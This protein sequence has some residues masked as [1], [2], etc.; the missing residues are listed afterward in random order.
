[1]RSLL[2]LAA[3]LTFTS[4]VRAQPETPRALFEE[5]VRAL[6]EQR[7]A[8]AAD[9]LA[10]S[11]ALRDSPSARYNRALALRGAGRYLEAIAEAE[12][13][14]EIAE[15]PR[16]RRVRP[17]VETLLEELRGAVATL[18]LVVTGGAETVLVDA[19]PVADVD[20]RHALRLDPGEHQVRV[21]RSGFA[22]LLRDIE[23]APGS[24]TT[25]DLDV[26]ATPLPASVRIEAEPATA[27]IVWDGR[28]V[29]EG[30]VDL[31]VPVERQG[32]R[33]R[34]EVR[35]DGFVSEEREL[36]LS[37]GESARLGLALSEEPAT[38]LRRKWWLWTTVAL[39]VGAV[40][41]VLV[42]VTR[43]DEDPLLQDI[44]NWADVLTRAP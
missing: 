34:L 27:H 30:E 28:V 1:M 3:A 7:F 32:R 13:Y 12:H 26:S 14:L 25:L 43:P 2:V 40:A 31:E 21:V 16:H 5:G 38:P 8:D 29:G 22:S 9:L 36:S 15:G 44:D 39:A 33:I 23:L 11:L 35:A 24:D 18:T 6:D 37:P 19:E 20:G 42:V 17:E 41:A 4:L 10:R